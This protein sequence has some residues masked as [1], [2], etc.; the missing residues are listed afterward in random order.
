MFDDK[1]IQFPSAL[2]EYMTQKYL[3]A[4]EQDLRFAHYAPSLPSLPPKPAWL[5]RAGR[6]LRRYV[7]TLWLA[8]RG[9]TLY[10]EDDGS[11]W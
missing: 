5:I 2:K 4:L 6:R 3:K 1:E 11:E 10:T 9:E 7:S 8:L